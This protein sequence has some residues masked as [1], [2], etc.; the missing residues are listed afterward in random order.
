MCALNGCLTD[1]YVCTCVCTGVL[2]L[3]R[4]AAVGAVTGHG[5]RKERGVLAG[6]GCKDTHVDTSNVPEFQK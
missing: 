2:A 3:K 5:K 6:E 1:V 4:G